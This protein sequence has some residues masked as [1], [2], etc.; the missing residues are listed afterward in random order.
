MMS[1]GTAEP[2]TLVS[3]VSFWP[4]KLLVIIS[5]LY[6][7]KIRA[8]TDGDSTQGATSEYVPGSNWVLSDASL[9]GVYGTPPL[10]PSCF[11]Y[12]IA[13]CWQSLVE[14][15]SSWML[16][17]GLLAEVGV[18]QAQ[19]IGDFPSSSSASLI[20]I[21]QE[22]TIVFMSHQPGHTEGCP[23]QLWVLCWLWEDRWQ[24]SCHKIMEYY[25]Q[26]VRELLYILPRQSYPFNRELT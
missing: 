22:H 12:A 21:R 19:W 11:L 2:Y 16:M 25:K 9:S 1:K 10:S 3:S 14:E 13:G 8:K 18:L 24:L 15:N 17:E 26:T 7:R 23:W 5:C 20:W 6:L 4:V